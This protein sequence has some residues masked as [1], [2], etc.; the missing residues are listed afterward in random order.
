MLN[1]Q[2][3]DGVILRERFLRPK[4]HLARIDEKLRTLPSR[5]FSAR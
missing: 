4:D 1:A 2:W 3:S 5:T